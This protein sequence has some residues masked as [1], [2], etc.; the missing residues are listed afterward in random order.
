MTNEEEVN[1]LVRSLVDGGEAQ[2]APP[3][4]QLDVSRVRALTQE[5][6]S[7]ITEDDSQQRPRRVSIAM[8]RAAAASV[9]VGLVGLAVLYA[10]SRDSQVRAAGAAEEQERYRSESI[11]STV[12]SATT[13]LRK[14]KGTCYVMCDVPAYGAL[15][16]PDAFK[17][18]ED[19][20]HDRVM[21]GEMTR[22]LWYSKEGDVAHITTRSKLSRDAAERALAASQRIRDLTSNK[23]NVT[24]SSIPKAS[25][26]AYQYWIWKGDDGKSMMALASVETATVP[27]IVHVTII[28]STEII[29]GFIA[30]FEKRATNAE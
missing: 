13:L 26:D 14:P 2:D 25:A 9:F 17:A 30:D 22:I 4:A 16:C 18:Y 28:D 29:D 8:M 23:K 7:Q 20:L 24:V 5:R 15:S 1:R 19:A 12:Q 6:L 3:E 27:A 11:V 21:S 10:L